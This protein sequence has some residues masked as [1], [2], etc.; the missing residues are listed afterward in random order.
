MCRI[1]QCNRTTGSD[2]IILYTDTPSPKGRLPYLSELLAG[3][4]KKRPT[5]QHENPGPV[6]TPDVDSPHYELGRPE[7][8]EVVEIKIGNLSKSSQSRK[9]GSQP[10]PVRVRRF[11]L[12]EEAL[13]YFQQFSQ[14]GAGV[15]CGVLNYRYM[16]VYT[17]ALG[18]VHFRFPL[19]RVC[20]SLL[21]LI[22]VVLMCR[23]FIG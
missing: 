19:S 15:W 7:P 9:E 4:R 2:I 1:A 17:I 16:T 13:E 14:V 18:M 8:T 10:G 3:R 20:N 11:R 23:F 6:S 5:A 22:S 12:T 21:L